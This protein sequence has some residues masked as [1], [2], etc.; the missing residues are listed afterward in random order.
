MLFVS[1]ALL[2]LRIAHVRD[3]SVVYLE[4]GFVLN[5]LA[6]GILVRSWR[7][8]GTAGRRGSL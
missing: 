2:I 5:S 7:R 4:S 3:H 8:P 1:D 6:V